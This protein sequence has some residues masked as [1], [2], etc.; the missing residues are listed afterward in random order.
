M[1]IEYGMY[2]TKEQKILII[3]QKINKLA[4]QAW[5]HSI[6]KNV[7][8]EIQDESAIHNINMIIANIESAIRVYQKEIDL[9]LNS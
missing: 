5:E 4:I 7:Y 6:D 1:T 3:E 8:I 2:L 9:L